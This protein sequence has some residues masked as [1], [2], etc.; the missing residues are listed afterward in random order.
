MSGFLVWLV[1]LIIVWIVIAIPTYFAAKLIVGSNATIWRAM[2]V[3]LIGPIVYAIVLFLASLFL[4]FLPYAT[5]IASILAFLAWGWVFK[6][7]FR[8]NWYRA[9]G[10]DLLATIISWVIVFVL[11]FLGVAL[12]L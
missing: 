12:V 5:V 3:T 6:R 4:F 2:A 8:T 7:Y 1:G 9:L 10:I 11:S